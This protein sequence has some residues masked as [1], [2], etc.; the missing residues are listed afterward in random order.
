MSKEKICVGI[1]GLTPGYHWA[2]ISHIPALMHLNNIYSM[3][4][5]A[6]RTAESSANTASAFGI[7]NAFSNA[8]D[9]IMISSL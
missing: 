2:A 8:Y 1:I 6:N 4:G 9:L 7:P 5:V 3:V